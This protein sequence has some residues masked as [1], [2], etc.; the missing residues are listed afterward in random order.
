MTKK[1]QQEAAIDL[2]EN[3]KFSVVDFTSG[4]VVKTNLDL[5]ELVIMLEYEHEDD[6]FELQVINQTTGEIYA[7]EKQIKLTTLENKK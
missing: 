1:Q 7:V 6:L 4:T 5:D 3:H 2:L